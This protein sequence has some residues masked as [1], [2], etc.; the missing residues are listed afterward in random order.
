MKKDKLIEMWSG[1]FTRQD[2]V[3][4]VNDLND[5]LE[6]QNKELIEF[7]EENVLYLIQ[8]SEPKVYESLK[9]LIKTNHK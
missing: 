8:Y 1:F 5:L 3:D 2:K 6:N 7:I 9:N 4:F